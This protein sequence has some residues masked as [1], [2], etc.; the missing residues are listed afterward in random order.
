[1]QAAQWKVASTPRAVDDD[2]FVLPI[3][4]D[5]AVDNAGRQLGTVP[6]TIARHDDSHAYS[7]AGGRLLGLNVPE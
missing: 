6:T 1:M 3:A 7:I 5:Q 4:R 2:Q